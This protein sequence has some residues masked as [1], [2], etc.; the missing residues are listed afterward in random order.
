LPNLPKVVIYVLAVDAAA[1]PVS[2]QRDLRGIRVMVERVESVMEMVEEAVRQDPKIA[3]RSLYRRA[4]EI[5][6]SIRDL[7][8]R[9]FHAAYAL[10]AKRRLGRRSGGAT[11][12][13]PAPGDVDREALRRVLLQF[14]EEVAGA[15]N[16]VAL[17]QVLAGIDS[18]VDDISKVLTP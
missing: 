13:R 8:V 1:S 17:V 11:G 15:R 2:P 3:S 4:C 5:E 7:S 16:R 10:P 12:D 14:A 9:Q 18:Y 6:A